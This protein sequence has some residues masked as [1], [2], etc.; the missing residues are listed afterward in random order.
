MPRPI[1]TIMRFNFGVEV[2]KAAGWLDF[3]RYSL[4]AF[5]YSSYNSDDNNLTVSPLNLS[6]CTV[7]V[8]E[9]IPLM[10][11]MEVVMV[12]MVWVLFMVIVSHVESS[13]SSTWVPPVLPHQQP[14][15]RTIEMGRSQERT[16]L[17]S[18]CHRE[19]GSYVLARDKNVRSS[20]NSF[21]P[22]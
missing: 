15:D 4:G 9:M 8:Q 2:S 14:A 21:F 22:M 6:A 19:W 17:E 10:M 11:V 1:K 13:E 16:K 18:F 5:I 3:K 20:A 12:V 7:W